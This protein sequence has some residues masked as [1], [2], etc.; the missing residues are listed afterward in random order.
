MSDKLDAE[1]ATY[2]THNKRNRWTSMLSTGYEAA[3]PAIKRLQKYA[4]DRMAT[5]IDQLI[6]YAEIITV[7]SEI[8][9]K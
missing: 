8:H 4:S 9:I 5:D 3:S 7:C 1:P 6:L 2:T